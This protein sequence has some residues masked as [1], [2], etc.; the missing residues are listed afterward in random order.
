M[1]LRQESQANQKREG[2]SDRVIARLLLGRGSCES[3][4]QRYEEQLCG[5][6]VSHSPALPSL[7]GEGQENPG[8]SGQG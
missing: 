6:R 5:W 2:E 3:G 8:C 7:G 4:L 1:K